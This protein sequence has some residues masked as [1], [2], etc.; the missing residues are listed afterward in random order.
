[1]PPVSPWLES[2]DVFASEEVSPPSMDVVV[3]LLLHP[4]Q[5]HTDATA[6]TYASA[7]K[8]GNLFIDIVSASRILATRRLH[9]RKH[10]RIRHYLASRYGDENDAVA[11]KQGNGIRRTRA[12]VER[13]AAAALVSRATPTVTTTTTPSRR[14]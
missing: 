1:M 4:M 11:A 9:G 14:G 3:L 10:V 6:K 7:K 13:A 8:P 2:L 12:P 5:S